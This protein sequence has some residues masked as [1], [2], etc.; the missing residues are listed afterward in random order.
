MSFH[1]PDLQYSTIWRCTIFE[2]PFLTY[3]K[4]IKLFLLNYFSKNTILNIFSCLCAFFIGIGIGGNPLSPSN[5]PF[6]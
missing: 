2:S 5:I 4:G 3:I 6:T 1:P